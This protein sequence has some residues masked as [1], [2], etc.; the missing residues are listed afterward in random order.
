M[1]DTYLRLVGQRRAQ[2]SY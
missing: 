2:A 1:L